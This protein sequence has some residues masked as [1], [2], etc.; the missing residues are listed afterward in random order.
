MSSRY[1][2]EGSLLTH[3]PGL[4]VGLFVTAAAVGAQV[5]RQAIPVLRPLGPIIARTSE[6]IQRVSQLRVLSDGRILVNDNARLRVL[7]FDSSL[8][9]ARSIIDTTGATRK[10]YGDHS[11]A[12]FPYT[13][14]SSLFLDQT[15]A[16]LLVVDPAGALGRILAA[17]PNPL[18]PRFPSVYLTN[19]LVSFDR[20]GHFVFEQARGI[21]RR[22]LAGLALPVAGGV[23]PDTVP[24]VRIGLLT[25]REDTIALLTVSASF[26]ATAQRIPVANPLPEADQWTMLKDGTVAIVRAHDYHIDWVAP[27]GTVASSPPIAHEWIHLTDSLK[28]AILDSARRADSLSAQA[29]IDSQGGIDAMVKARLAA[30]PSRAGQPPRTSSQL[31][32][33]ILSTLSGPWVPPWAL[34]DYVPPFAPASGPADRP[35]KADADDEVWIRVRLPGTQGGTEVYDVVNRQGVLTDRIRLPGETWIVGFGPGVVYLAAREGAGIQVA[36]A[37]IR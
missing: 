24:L 7:L 30:A 3:T 27:N 13:G 37:R 5:S 36:R 23:A 15:S 26:A 34:P 35:V 22:D 9:H 25:R 31:A 11:G 29:V 16:A 20:Q 33:S 18:Q 17:P 32:A 19:P 10:A 2:W 14:D 1:F 21:V 4:A 12:L 8:A 28:A 6:P